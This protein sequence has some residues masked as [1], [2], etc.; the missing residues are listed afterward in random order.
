MKDT[1]D[2]LSLPEKPVEADWKTN[3]FHAT[4][5]HVWVHT[6]TNLIIQMYVALYNIF[7]FSGEKQKSVFTCVFTYI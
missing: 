4:N 2:F 6:H 3:T 5:I 7:T 1:Y